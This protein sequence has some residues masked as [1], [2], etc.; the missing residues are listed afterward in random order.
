MSVVI[1]FIW[2]IIMVFTSS[3]YFKNMVRSTFIYNCPITPDDVTVENN[4]WSQ[5]P[6][7]QSQNSDETDKTVGDGL[8][9]ST[10]GLR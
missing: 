7:Y 9:C 4:L 5:P 3:R 6:L 1:K 10:T 2:V 8:Y